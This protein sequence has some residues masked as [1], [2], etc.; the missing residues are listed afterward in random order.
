LKLFEDIDLTAP[1]TQVLEQ[2]VAI[3]DDSACINEAAK[4]MQRK[5]VSSVLVRNSK[6]GELVGI[7]TE[8][9]I[10]YRAVA[11]SLGMFKVNIGKIM[12]TPLITVDKETPCIEAIKIMR[13]KRLRRLPIMD[14]GN[15]LGVATLMSIV[16]N[17][18]TRNVELIELEKPP[19]SQSPDLSCPYCESKFVDKMELSKHIDRIHLGSGLLEGDLRKWKR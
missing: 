19:T 16:G 8:R 17:M 10:I 14:H 9:D 5:G 15:I 3:L 4:E 6:S 12:S 13:E 18:P 1:V 2:N 11:K 7:V